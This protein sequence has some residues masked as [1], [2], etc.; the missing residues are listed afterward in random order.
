VDYESSWMSKKVSVVT[1][2]PAGADAASGFRTTL[3]QVIDAADPLKP[4][5]TFDLHA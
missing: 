2:R 1:L 5:M 4:I 3:V